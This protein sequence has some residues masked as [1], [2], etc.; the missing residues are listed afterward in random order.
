MTRVVVWPSRPRGTYPRQWVK[1]FGWH[2]A[3][4]WTPKVAQCSAFVTFRLVP[5]H[6]GALFG[7]WV[8]LDDNDERVIRLGIGFAEVQTTIIRWLR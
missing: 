3:V 7:L 1:V 6:G 4:V 2:Q 5:R 8:G